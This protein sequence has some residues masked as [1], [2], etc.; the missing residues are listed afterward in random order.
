MNSSDLNQ[1][2][3]RSFFSVVGL[4]G[5]SS[6]SAVLGFAAFF[7]LTL[8][9]GVHLLG[10]Y[11]TV[12][13]AMS[14]FNYFTNLGLAAALIQKKKT[15][16]IDLN[17]SFFMQ[18]FLTTIAVII[19]WV[20]SDQIL[21]LYKD[22]PEGSE[23]LYKSMLISFFLLSLKTIPSVLL[24]KDLQIYKV[25]MV[26]ILENTV[27]YLVIIVLV[28]MGLEIES[29]VA[30][31]IIRSIVGLAAIY[32]FRPW[33]FK[34]QFSVAA[35]RKLLKFGIPFQGNSFLALI[36]DDMLII[37]LG[38][39]I[40][41]TN[42]GYVMFAKKYAEFSIRL[43]MDN[44]NR[45]AFPLF[46]RFQKSRDLL[47]KSLSKVLFYESVL[48]FPFIVGL[49]FVF[50]SLLKVIPGY[51]DKWE[52][53]LFSFYFFS[54]SAIFVSVSSPLIN[55]FNAIGK[56]MTSLK[57]MVLWTVLTWLLIPTFISIAGY[58]GIA[59]AFLMMSLTAVFVV[60][61]AK[62]YITFSMIKIYKK[63]L[64]CLL[65]MSIYLVLAR[66]IFINI[67]QSP[68][69]HLVFSV[70]GAALIYFYSM[71]RISGK[72]IFSEVLNLLNAKKN[73]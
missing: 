6:Y 73:E 20:F 67:Y 34:P 25:S 72:E 36:K 43:V 2:K 68:L 60:M 46:S 62:K 12:L 56:V 1:V 35:A 53:A 19:G 65:F 71:V 64:I 44:V 63:T 39:S 29:L 27:F 22:L 54:L 50:D 28:L 24:E 9:S 14:F 31:V 57:F 30:A 16:E 13:A 61:V 70:P 41:L 52:A 18:F 21:S 40:G 59:I 15:E 23:V 51:F 48:I 4:I 8:K 55:L 58:N 66:V 42:L 32:I 47:V 5:Q 11:G 69:L 3:S 10:V 17:S 33:I 26:Q 37:Y 45:V 7:I 49:L 38:S